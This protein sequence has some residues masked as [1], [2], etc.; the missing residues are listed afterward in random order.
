VADGVQNARRVRVAGDDHFQVGPDGAR[1][2][3]QLQ[4]VE[5]VAAGAGDQHVIRRGPELRQRLLPVV[6]IVDPAVA[7]RQAAGQIRCTSGSDR[8]TGQSAN[9]QSRSDIMSPN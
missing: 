9:S 4:A 7:P 1:P 5:T 6:Q 2:P 8:P 3:Q